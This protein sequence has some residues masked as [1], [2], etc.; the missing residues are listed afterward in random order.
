LTRSIATDLFLGEKRYALCAP[1]I[2]AG[3]T[4]KLDTL[5]HLFGFT[6][7]LKGIGE[8]GVAFD[9]TLLIAPTFESGSETADVA[10][11]VIAPRDGWKERRL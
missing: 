5:R 8:P 4:E 1:E 11:R 9:I 7:E 6:G 2:L 10:P 3:G